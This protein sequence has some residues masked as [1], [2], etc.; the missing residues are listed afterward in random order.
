MIDH[1]YKIIFIHIPRCGGT[2]IEKA[3]TGYD[4]WQIA[5]LLKHAPA[6][7]YKNLFPRYW[8]EYFKFSI[9]RN[10]YTRFRSLWKYR[11]AY[12]LSKDLSGKIKL[13]KYLSY[14]HSNN[15]TIETQRNLIKNGINIAYISSKKFKQNRVYGNYLNEPLDAIYNFESLPLVFEELGR[16]LGIDITQTHTEKSLAQPPELSKEVYNVINKICSKDFSTFGYDVMNT[17]MQ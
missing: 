10:P 11:D 8:K 14:F 17:K 5:P 2:S 1:K 7:I 16:K 3:I 15:Q 4:Y 12:G 13:K 9:V 6:N